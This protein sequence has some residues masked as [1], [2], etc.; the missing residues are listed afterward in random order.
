RQ[1]LE[2]V[3][4]KGE[5]GEELRRNAK[6]WKNFAREALKEGGSSDKNLRNFLHHDN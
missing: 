5:K 3:M 2:L 6:K 1:C 4:G